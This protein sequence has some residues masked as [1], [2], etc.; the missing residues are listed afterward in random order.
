MFGRLSRG[1]SVD[2]NAFEDAVLAATR[3]VIRKQLDCGIDIGNNGEQA[4][5]SFFTY[6]QHRMSG[7]GGV[8]ERPRLSDVAKYPGFIDLSRM[9]RERVLVDLLHPPK[10]VGAVSYRDR[11]PLERECDDFDKVMTEQGAPFLEPFMTAPSPGIIA[12]AMLNEH[13]AN[14]GD[15]IAALADA[16]RVEYETIIARGY[17]L[18]I[19]A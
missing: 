14:I 10:A 12:A 8:S 15:Y 16:L 17:V 1:E 7:F 18:Q 4:R 9:F 6:V 13:Y 2:Q 3:Q 5:E 11:G 19:D